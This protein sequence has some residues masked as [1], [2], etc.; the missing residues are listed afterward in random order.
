MA[1]H[2]SSHTCST[3]RSAAV[4]CHARDQP[5][6]PSPA[7]RHALQPVVGHWRRLPF[8]RLR[9]VWLRTC[10]IVGQA[11]TESHAVRDMFAHGGGGARAMRG[12]G[13]GTD[14]SSTTPLASPSSAVCAVEGSGIG[15]SCWLCCWSCCGVEAA[16]LFTVPSQGSAPSSMKSVGGRCSGSYSEVRAGAVCCGGGGS[17]GV[18]SS[19]K[20]QSAADCALRPRK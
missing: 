3:R 16:T 4:L 5:L 19:A 13:A 12:L 9:L 20:H 18:S 17:G 6:H 14:A 1:C 2:P 7:P 10:W 8:R 15:T 11:C